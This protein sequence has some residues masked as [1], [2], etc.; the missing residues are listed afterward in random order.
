MKRLWIMALA[1]GSPS[2]LLPSAIV[3]VMNFMVWGREQLQIHK[4]AEKGTICVNLCALLTILHLVR[5][6]EAVWRC[7]HWQCAAVPHLLGV[8]HC[9]GLAAV[10]RQDSVEGIRN[11]H[12]RPRRV[13][14][15]PAIYLG[16]RSGLQ[17]KH[18]GSALQSKVFL[19]WGTISPWHASAQITVGRSCSDWPGCSVG[20]GC[21]RTWET[22]HKTN[23]PHFAAI[24]TGTLTPRIKDC[25]IAG[26]INSPLSRINA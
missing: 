16:T 13:S 22:S 7:C 14:S 10:L 8:G 20:R 5:C 2:H 9:Q 23:T 11:A 6:W 17:E 26:K 24:F 3:A 1:P 15:V 21:K 4:E 12:S 25:P 19:P 18:F